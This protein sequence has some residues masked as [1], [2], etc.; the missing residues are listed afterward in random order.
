MGNQKQSLKKDIKK[1]SLVLNKK[2]SQALKFRDKQVKEFRAM[3]DKKAD[4]KIELI[5][6]EDLS[7]QISAKEL[8]AISVIVEK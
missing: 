1:E 6:R 4:I 2:H 7:E 3:L 5:K 8:A